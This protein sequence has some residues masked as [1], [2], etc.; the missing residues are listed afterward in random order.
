MLV[1]FQVRVNLQL[2][3]KQRAAFANIYVD[4]VDEFDTY[5]RVSL[6]PDFAGR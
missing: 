1:N 4:T 5:L 6:K 3:K 2:R